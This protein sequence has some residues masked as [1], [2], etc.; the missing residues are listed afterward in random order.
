MREERGRDGGEG[1][2]GPG[3]GPGCWSLGYHSRARCWAGDAGTTQTGQITPDKGG[4]L[5]ATATGVRRVSK[6]S[7]SSAKRGPEGRGWTEG[8]QGR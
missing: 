6:V 3:R 4:R 5:S 1:E 7:E 8:T 2:G